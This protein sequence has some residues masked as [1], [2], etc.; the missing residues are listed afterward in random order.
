MYEDRLK[1]TDNTSIKSA[2]KQL[3]VYVKFTQDSYNEKVIYFRNKPASHQLEASV[4][5]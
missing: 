1:L 4:G 3:R 5:K 2:M